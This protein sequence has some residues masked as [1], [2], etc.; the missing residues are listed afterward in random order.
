[1]PRG[2]I[3]SIEYKIDT[4]CTASYTLEYTGTRFLA[5]FGYGLDIRTR[6]KIG[7]QCMMQ[8]TL[9]LFGTQLSEFDL[10]GM[11]LPDGVVSRRKK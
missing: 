1:M 5:G 4:K 9:C 10:L 3:H 2:I 8:Y 11:Q 6:P 7:F